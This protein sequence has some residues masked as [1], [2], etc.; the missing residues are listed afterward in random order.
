LLKGIGKDRG[1]IEERR[2]SWGAEYLE[3]EFEN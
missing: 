3:H 1:G 2:G